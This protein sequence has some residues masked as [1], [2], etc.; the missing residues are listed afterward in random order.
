MIRVPFDNPRPL[1]CHILL[2]TACNFDCDGC[3]YRKSEPA[4]IPFDKLVCL[5]EDLAFEG[6]YSVAFGGGEPTLYPKLNEAITEA[7]KRGLYVAVTTNGLNTYVFDRNPDRVHISYS[8]MHRAALRRAKE[9]ALHFV[10][11]RHIADTLDYYRVQ[12][13]T[14]GINYIYENFQH[15]KLIDTI[16]HRAHNI[17]I[18]MKKPVDVEQDWTEPLDYIEGNRERYWLDA[19]L[20]KLVK[21]I[22]CRQ[23]VSSLSIDQNLIARRCSNTETGVPYT[24]LKEVWSQIQAITDCI[25]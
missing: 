24:T 1:T 23:G 4:E 11:W 21:G 6:V 16:F 14:V 2:T 15:F 3:F 22:P 7:K 8:S 5:L 18:L 20:V 12:G 13:I 19:C 10:P 17:T 25:I 9:G